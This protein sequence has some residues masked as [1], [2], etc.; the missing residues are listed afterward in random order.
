MYI[1]QRQ[2]KTKQKLLE[3]NAITKV[4]MY[5]NYNLQSVCHVSQ[6]SS[7][8][9]GP[10]RMKLCVAFKN[11]SGKVLSLEFASWNGESWPF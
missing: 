2:R 1:G 3:I 7:R 6:N 10:L 5:V 11:H 8:T 9:V 4:M